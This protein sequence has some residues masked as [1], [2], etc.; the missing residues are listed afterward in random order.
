MQSIFGSENGKY[1]YFVDLRRNPHSLQLNS[2][3][4]ALCGFHTI[5]TNSMA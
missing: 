4:R 1:V 5:D 2:I 3:T